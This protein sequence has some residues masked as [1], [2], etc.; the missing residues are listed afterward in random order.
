MDQGPIEMTRM[1]QQEQLPKPIKHIQ[2][3]DVSESI[4]AKLSTSFLENDSSEME[5]W[6]NVLPE[7]ELK[8]I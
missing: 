3:S 4:V 6:F 7:E 5:M 2:L 1:Q 8:R